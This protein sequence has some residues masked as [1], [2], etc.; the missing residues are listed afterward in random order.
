MEGAHIHWADVV[1]HAVEGQQVIATGITPSGNIHVG[2]MR[3]VVTGDAIFRAIRDAEKAARLIYIADTYDPLRTVYPFLPAAYKKYVGMPLSEIP[4]PFGCCPS[5]AE[6]YLRPFS[7]SLGELDIALEVY[8]ADR[9]YKDGLYTEATKI[10]LEQRNLIADIIERISKRKL[11][12]GWSPYNPLCERCRRISAAQIIEHVPERTAVLYKCYCGAEGVADYSRGQGKLAWRVDWPARWKILGVTI[13]P[14]GK[15][16]A[17]AGGSYDTGKRISRNVYGY[18]PPVPVP[19][20][21]IHLKGRGKMSSSKGVTITIQEMLESAPADVLRYMIIKTKPEKLI[22]FDPGL[23]L[24]TL[25]DE[26]DRGEGRAFEL[27]RITEGEC[28]VPFRHMVTAVQIAHNCDELVEV[29]SRSGYE[30]TDMTALRKRA[31]NVRNWL[32][33]FAP[34]FV[35]F[36]VQ[37]TLPVQVKTLTQGQRKALEKLAKALETDN[38]DPEWLHNEVYN[39]SEQVG[40]HSKEAFKAIYISLLA[41]TSG[42]RAGWFLATLDPEFLI[43]RFREAA[44]DVS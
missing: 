14:F 33:R 10:A 16:H 25:V 34:P 35:K 12:T 9:M 13:E 37:R 27:S 8:R 15:D 44:G 42:P 32:D 4:D 18:T 6:H 41:K 22:D 30:T 21:H 26:F 5:Y 3:E 7:E 29:L 17:V 38:S 19:Y 40:I 36:E 39:I 20:G 43:A 28:N 1:A 2:N 24:L 11:P 31:R 23:G